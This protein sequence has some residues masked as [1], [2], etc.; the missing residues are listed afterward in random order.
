MTRKQEIHVDQA[1][2]PS[3]QKK[4]LRK[5]LLLVV[6]YEQ[7]R[8]LTIQ[9]MD[10]RTIRVEMSKSSPCIPKGYVPNTTSS[11][12]NRDDNKIVVTSII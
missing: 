1:S 3:Q 7:N 11:S 4:L 5:H 2:F 9:T 8:V 12:A 6:V 10:G